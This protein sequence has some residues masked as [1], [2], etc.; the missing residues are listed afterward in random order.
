MKIHL[1]SS[2]NRP[3]SN[4]RSYQYHFGKQ[5]SSMMKIFYIA[6]ILM[7]VVLS[8]SAAAVEADVSAAPASSGHPEGH[9]RFLRSA[10]TVQVGHDH[11]KEAP[12]A[13]CG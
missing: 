8:L 1:R 6:V 7:G 12:K 9:P 10:E 2:I 4:W 3:L 5:T 11:S 13:C